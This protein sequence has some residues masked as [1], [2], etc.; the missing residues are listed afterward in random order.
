MKTVPIPVALLEVGKPLPV[1]VWSDSG[2]LLLRRGQ[3]IVSEQ[4]RD[5]LHAF[6]ASTSESDG[7]AWQRAYERMV[8]DMLRSGAALE[9]VARAAMPA[10]IR[11]SDYVV[12]QPPNG[13]WLDLQAVLRGLLYQGGLAVHP[14]ARLHGLEEKAMALLQEDVDG[15]LF[16]LFQALGD[17]SLGYS[18]THA[19]LCAVVC[20]RTGTKLGLT[21]L[22]RQPLVRAALTMNIGMAREQD[23]MARQNK[24]IDAQ[25]RAL[26]AQHPALGES[27]LRALGVDDPLQLDLVRWHHAPDAPQGLPSNLMLRRLLHLADV[28]VARTAARR[29]RSAQSP[30]SAV[31]N[32]VFGAGGDELGLGS[33]MAQAVG[34]YPPGTYVKLANGEIAVAVQ[35]GERAN[36][37]WVISIIGNDAI[38]LAQY[39]CKSTAQPR[40]AISAPVAFEKIKVLVNADK[41]QKARERIPRP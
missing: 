9:Q 16:A 5:K 4:H 38:P 2:Q 12:G 1:D 37:P 23:S 31:K 27:V 11:E 6:K 19:L 30:V 35:R 15:S 25:Q 36:T 22:Q 34:F 40:D 32:M 33:A 26:V 7:L 41:V 24:A 3:P 18:A 21:P 8:H 14:L 17:N 20:E 29:T 28:F 10:E 13:G 39:L